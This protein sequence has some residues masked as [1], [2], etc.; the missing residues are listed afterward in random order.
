MIAISLCCEANVAEASGLENSIN[1]APTKFVS[2]VR[3]NTDRLSSHVS[4]NY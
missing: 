1:S 4:H 2:H 3:D